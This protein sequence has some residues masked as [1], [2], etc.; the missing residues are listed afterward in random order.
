MNFYKLCFKNKG[1]GSKD[2]NDKSKKDKIN[3]GLGSKD[4]NN[5]SNKKK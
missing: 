4:K 1:L 2:K 5:K 3:K